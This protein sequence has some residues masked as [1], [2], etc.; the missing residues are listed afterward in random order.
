MTS[1]EPIIGKPLPRKEDPK[2]LRGGGRYTDDANA[3]GQAHGC[4]VRSV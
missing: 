2:L 3:E 1:S 4:V